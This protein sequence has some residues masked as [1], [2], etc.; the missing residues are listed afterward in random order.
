MLKRL[1]FIFIGFIV[2]LLAAII[3]LPIL[4]KGDLQTLA[5]EEINKSINA[6]FEFED[7]N[8]SLIRSFPDFSVCLE[9]F[10]IQGI[11]QFEGISL[12]KGK[13]LC[14]NA[15]V[16]S[17]ISKSNSIE[18][19]SVYLD[20]PSIN[21]VIAA[22][23]KA[24][25]DI[26]KAS[27]STN[28]NSSSTE[29]Y[30]LNLDKYEIANGDFS[31]IDKASGLYMHAKHIDHKGTGSFKS[32]IFDL[33]TETTADNVIFSTGGINYI[34]RAAINLDAIFNIDLD[35]SKY[36]LKENDLKLNALQLNADG[37]VQTVGDDIKM[38]LKFNAPSNSL[39]EII[40][41]VPGAY[42]KDYSGVNA[43]GA[44]KFSGFAKGTYN[45][46]KNQIP[47]FAL[48]IDIKQGNVQY[49]DLPMGIKDINSS[50]S[51]KSPSSNFDD[52]VINIPQL[53]LNVANEPFE[54]RLLLKTP[55]SDP[56]IDT[57]MKGKLD[58]TQVAK[59]FPMEGV[60]SISGIIVADFMIKTKMSTLDN[61]DY[62][63]A[64]MSGKL[65]INNM[66]YEAEGTPPVVINSLQVDFIPQFL[67]INQFDAKLGKSDIKA[68]GKIDNFLAYFSP[69]KT[70]KGDLVI[71][72]TFFDA[73]EW[74]VDEEGS[75]SSSQNVDIQ[76]EDIDVFDRFDFTLNTKIDRIKYSPYD[77]RNNALKGHFTSNEIS[78]DNFETKIGK[79]DFRGRGK[80][81]N[82]FAYLFED[83][84]LRGDLSL[85]SDYLDANEFLADVPI[86]AEAKSMANEENLEPF[87][88]PE[89][90]EIGITA[91]IAKMLYTDLDITNVKGKI[92][93]K[94]EAMSMD[95]VNM[96]TLGG[97]MNISGLYNTKDTE[98]P[99][100]KLKYGVDKLNF[101]QTFEKFNT[102]KALMPMAKFMN[103][104][105]S[106]DLS[107]NGLL[108]K[109]MYPDL[110]SLT[111]DGFIQTFNAVLNEFEPLEK[112]GEKLNIKWLKTIKLDD[113]KNWFTVKDG[114][115]ILDESKH[116]IR[117]ISML[118]A[119]SHGLESDMDYTIKAKIPKELLGDNTATQ[120]ANKGLDFLNKEA[121]KLGLDIANGEFVN[122]LINITGTMSKPKLK[123]T[124]TGAEGQ[125]VK[126]VAKDIVNQVKET[127]KDTV[128]KVVKEKVD[129]G[130]AKLAAEK[131]KLE[132]EADAK[133]AAIRAKAKKQVDAARANA[134]KQADLAK[135]KAYA[136]ADKAL[137]KVKN[138][139]QKIAAKEAAK[140]AKRQADKVHASALKRVDN[141]TQKI[142]DRA[143]E[144]TKK[145]RSSYDKRISELEKK[146]GM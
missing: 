1:I 2:L 6:K 84:I 26:T 23:G 123:I 82:I 94:D 65:A 72:S 20:E 21:V 38:D 56:D 96:K 69:K 115:V 49:P 107:F 114:K 121:S 55:M 12:A 145:I 129:D 24:N 103:G 46:A 93:V 35:N 5:S 101:K 86:E 89:N 29:S 116:Q 58:L 92:E 98:T 45:G 15:N 76:E 70:M 75:N 32:T 81:K 99:K 37:Y 40:S 74:I 139:L 8:V 104:D 80:L 90:V 66:N 17:V 102:F 43:E 3:V 19:K 78:L 64:D 131:A 60:T 7:V 16:W 10:D 119:G 51:V 142:M 54:G 25:Y 120:I 52:M 122:V 73:D 109:D 106:T 91:D 27:D 141:T 77:L 112:I 105:F 85:K 53:N 61:G 135:N 87:L 144:Q 126:D 67:K 137:E 125:S 124:P 11:D 118:V 68:S 39:K 113:S 130:K 133:I 59:A 140:I 9:D 127:V 57:K 71:S 14:I 110:N 136:E 100:F 146:A 4:F 48:D 30:Q 28:T 138:P 143:D 42:T 128:T 47:A 63:S 108:G 50:I 62:D 18:V 34:S 97:N 33:I 134:K 36:T 13:S 88:V 95:R 83:G 44:V 132:A 41:L 117:N 22:S 79:S 31:Y 111:A